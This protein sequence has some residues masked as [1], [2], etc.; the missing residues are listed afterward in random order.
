MSEEWEHAVSE[1]LG[2]GPQ[3]KQMATLIAE[4]IARYRSFDTVPGHE[5]GITKRRLEQMSVVL[6]D[7]HELATRFERREWSFLD[8][9]HFLEF[10]QPNPVDLE[11]FSQA[12]PMLSGAA[13][14]GAEICT[15]RRGRRLNQPELVAFIRQLADCWERAY[16]V[17]APRSR[18]TR[19][20]RLVIALAQFVNQSWRPN[21]DLVS[22]TLKAKGA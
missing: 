10:G 3:S 9:G 21:G 19:F 13:L 2:D 14:R 4:E 11:R 18:K 6:R 12:L 15:P 16:G 1:I 7:L 17:P 8:Q 20:S 22:R 5:L